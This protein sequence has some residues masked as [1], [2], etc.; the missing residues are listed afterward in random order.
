M[1][2]SKHI[3]LGFYP[4][5]VIIIRYNPSFRIRLFLKRFT[6][7]F[8][9]NK[10]LNGLNNEMITNRLFTPFTGFWEVD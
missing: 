8:L 10:P 2:M 7:L 3:F 4:L 5:Y 6:A 1:S 9:Q